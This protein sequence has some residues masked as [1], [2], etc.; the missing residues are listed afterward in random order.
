[1]E[2]RC[3]GKPIYG[4]KLSAFDGGPKLLAGLDTTCVKNMY[5]LQSGTQNGNFPRLVTMHVFAY[6]NV[7]FLFHKNKIRRIYA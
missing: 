6:F 3:V 1:M 2:N 5:L 7:M 4:L